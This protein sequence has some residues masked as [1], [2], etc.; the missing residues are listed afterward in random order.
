[1]HYRKSDFKHF[2]ALENFTQNQFPDHL[3]LLK[4]ALTFYY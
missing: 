3:S 1:M 2:S 4:I